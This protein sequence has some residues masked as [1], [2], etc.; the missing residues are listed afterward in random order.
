MLRRILLILS[1]VGLV[2]SVGLWGFT[3]AGYG[4]SYVPD[5][6][7]LC[8]SA[9][10]GGIWVYWPESAFANPQVE[11]LGQVGAAVRPQP[12]WGARLG[13]ASPVYYAASGFIKHRPA[14]PKRLFLPYFF[15]VG[16]QP[17]HIIMSCPLGLPV[18]IFALA[19][20]RIG[21][22]LRRRRRLGLC[23]ACGYNL[24]GSPGACPECGQERK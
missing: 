16:G 3:I 8:V 13:G 14:L 11:W 4:A 1:I 19:S 6:R 22:S 12:V 18:V 20:W 23:V 9:S 24:T 15:R 7:R 2:G 5:S 10:A 17:N 21:M